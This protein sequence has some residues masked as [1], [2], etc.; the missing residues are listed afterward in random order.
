MSRKKV[1]NERIVSS[2]WS[3]TSSTSPR[4]HGSSVQMT[5]TIAAI[6]RRIHGAIV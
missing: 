5:G 4:S 6:T 1:G 2:T 3:T